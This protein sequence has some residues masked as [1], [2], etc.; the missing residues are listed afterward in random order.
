MLDAFIIEQLR[1]REEQERN[2]AEHRN[3][4]DLPLPAPFEAPARE[5]RAQHQ[6]DESDGE[7]GVTVVEFS[8]SPS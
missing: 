4:L 7:R 6:D 1:K 8:N 5:P 3:R 2:R